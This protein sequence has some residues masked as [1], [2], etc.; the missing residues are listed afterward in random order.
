[1]RI[2]ISE[3]NLLPRAL[4]LPFHQIYLHIAR[5]VAFAA[6]VVVGIILFSP[7]LPI[8]KFF[9]EGESKIELEEVSA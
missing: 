5:V 8:L 3:T 6:P 9:F 2:V 4:E 7:D 1:M